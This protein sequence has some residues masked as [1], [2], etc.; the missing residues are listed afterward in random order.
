[1]NYN[2]V[3]D[4]LNERLLVRLNKTAMLYANN[5]KFGIVQPLHAI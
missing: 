2:R 5:T 3:A 4:M 1:M